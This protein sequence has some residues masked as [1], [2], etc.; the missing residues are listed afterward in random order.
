MK[1]ATLKH[2][3]Q[4][5]LIQQDRLYIISSALQ[6]HGL[7]APAG[8]TLTMLNLLTDWRRNLDLLVKLSGHLGSDEH[9]QLVAE[10]EL[11]APVPRPGKM[12]FAGA[13]YYAHI[14]QFGQAGGQT[15]GH[16]FGQAGGQTFE[17]SKMAPY[18]FAKLPDSV[19]GPYDP[20]VL[21]IGYEQVDWELEL[22]LVIGQEGRS[23][24]VERALEYVAGFVVI[25]DITAR[26][27]TRRQDWPMLGSDWFI[28]KSADTFCPMGPYLVPKEFAG[29]YHDLRA[30]LWVNEQGY[31]DFN[32][33]DM[34][35]Q[36]EELIAWAAAV[37]TLR[38]G[39]VLST[40]SGPGNGAAIGRWLQPGDVI[41]AEIAGLGRQKTP[42]VAAEKDEPSMKE[43]ET[44]R[45]IP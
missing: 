19:I 29:E 5:A 36:P 35:Y 7:P 1:I 42:V 10:A 40:G 16:Q 39:D 41:E 13:N 28:S 17:K 9:Y 22:G 3:G 20:L 26:D 12:L 32:T 23:L 27:R 37:T 45:T 33:S 38:S 11:A 21:P 2:H 18:L 43:R 6:R 31:Q 44:R 4:A 8:A 15:P 34:I 25:N 14:R 30:Q 24:S